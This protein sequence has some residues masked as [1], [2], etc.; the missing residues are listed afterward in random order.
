MKQLALGNDVRAPIIRVVI[1]RTVVTPGNS[2]SLITLNPRKGRQKV[3]L[4]TSM[5]RNCLSV[6]LSI[7]RDVTPGIKPTD[8]DASWDG[9][10]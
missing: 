6:C 10:Q 9:G 2:G 7:S 5:K 3:H 4:N 1:V 8:T